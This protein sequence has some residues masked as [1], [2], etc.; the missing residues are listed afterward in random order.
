M[1]VE[2][3]TLKS[4]RE[5][6]S[7]IVNCKMVFVLHKR[8]SGRKKN[9]WD[10]HGLV[11]VTKYSF[12][13]KNI[14]REDLTKNPGNPSGA[15]GSKYPCVSGKFRLPCVHKMRRDMQRFYVDMNPLPYPILNPKH[16]ERSRFMDFSINHIQYQKR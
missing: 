3:K 4:K 14:Q 6:N 1:N 5:Y 11:D 12:R 15:F 13:K 7:Y 10:V 8:K 2:I 9:H 16:R